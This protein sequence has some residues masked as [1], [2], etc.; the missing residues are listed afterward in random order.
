MLHSTNLS[1]SQCSYG[2]I[3]PPLWK[4]K[5]IHRIT[6]LLAIHPISNGKSNSTLLQHFTLI[7]DANTSEYYFWNCYP[8][9]KWLFIQMQTLRIQNYHNKI[10]K[11]KIVPTICWKLAIDCIW[12]GYFHWKFLL[13][14]CVCVCVRFAFLSIEAWH[15]FCFRQLPTESF[16]VQLA[17]QSIFES[18]TSKKCTQTKYP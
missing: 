9:R 17:C 18:L 8:V 11:L 4:F 15:S 14:W 1:L 2:W 6:L 13:S 16:M 3:F 7:F 12:A 10:G 5:R